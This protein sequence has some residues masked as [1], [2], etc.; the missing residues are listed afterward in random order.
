MEALV[1]LF[2][3]SLVGLGLAKSMITSI[4]LQKQAE[5]GNLARNLAVSKAEELSGV[6]IDNLNNSYDSTE[7]NLTVTGHNIKFTRVTDVTVNSDGSRTID[8]SVSST[9]FVMTKP[10]TYSTRFAPWES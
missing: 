9:S 7:S 2:L 3:F 8:I 6:N 1:A 10:V 5:I 4:S